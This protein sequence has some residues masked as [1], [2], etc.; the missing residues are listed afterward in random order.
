MFDDGSRE[1]DPKHVGFRVEGNE[2]SCK[3]GQTV[4]ATTGSNGKPIKGNDVRLTL[5]LAAQKC[6]FDSVQGS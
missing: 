5:D 3:T 6:L 4:F 1:F 2:N